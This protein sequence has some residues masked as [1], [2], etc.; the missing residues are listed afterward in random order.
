M[1]EEVLKDSFFGRRKTSVL[2]STSYFRDRDLPASVSH[3]VMVL[4]Y[5]AVWFLSL[6]ITSNA[7]QPASPV[8]PITVIEMNGNPELYYVSLLTHRCVMLN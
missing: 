2:E 1:R 6:L 3:M 8:G 7:S 5:R 4:K